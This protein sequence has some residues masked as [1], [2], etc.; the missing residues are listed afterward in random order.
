ML[1]ANLPPTQLKTWLQAHPLTR[2]TPQ[3]DT[4]AKALKQKLKRVAEQD[5]CLAEQEHELGVEALAVPLRDMRGDTV[6]A[7]NLVRTGAGAD[8]PDLATRWLALLQQ[9]AQSL[10]GFI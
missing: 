9:T 10:R 1:L 3:T 4:S 7:L 2:L 5:F 8:E 6:A